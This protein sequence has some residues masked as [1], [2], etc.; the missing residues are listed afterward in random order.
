VTVVGG[1]VA[2]VSA[3]PLHEMR[4]E[5]WEL[6]FDLNLHYVARYARRSVR[7]ASR[8]PAGRSSASGR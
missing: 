7:F 8:G 5:D 1:Q 3:V 4:D 2:F 6:V